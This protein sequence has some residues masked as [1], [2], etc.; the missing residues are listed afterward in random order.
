MP[1]CT[2]SQHPREFGPQLYKA[3][4]PVERLFNR[5]KHFQRVATCYDKLD[6]CYLV[7]VMKASI[8][9]CLA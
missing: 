6:G 4:N 9:I 7:F 1:P 5:I 3:H 2:N 8:L